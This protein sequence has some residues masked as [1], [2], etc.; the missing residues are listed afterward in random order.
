MTVIV[1]HKGLHVSDREYT[2]LYTRHLAI[3]G[4]REDGICWEQTT[5]INTDNELQVS[6]RIHGLGELRTLISQTD[7]REG[8]KDIYICFI[9]CL[10]IVMS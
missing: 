6:L 4:R 8:S 10:N 3:R 5:A 1:C 2:L 7:A 9:T